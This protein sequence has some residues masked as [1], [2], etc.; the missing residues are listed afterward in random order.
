MKFIKSKKFQLSSEGFYYTFD[1]E[2]DKVSIVWLYNGN[3]G[4]W[5]IIN[6]SYK[7][8][9]LLDNLYI[10]S[11]VEMPQKIDMDEE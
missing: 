2:K 3:G 6:N 9:F 8:I 11:S 10:G 4:T 7:P 1:K 5:G